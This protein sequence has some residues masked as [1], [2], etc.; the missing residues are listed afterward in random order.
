MMTSSS[1][2]DVNSRAIVLSDLN[3]S[4]RTTVEI[5]MTTVQTDESSSTDVL[6]TSSAEMLPSSSTESLSFNMEFSEETMTILVPSSSHQSLQP[7]G[8]NA[9]EPTSTLTIDETSSTEV[10]STS[11]VEMLPSASRESPSVSV[12]SSGETMTILVPSSSHQLLQSSVSSNAQEPTS[13]L[14]IDETS[15]TGVFSTPSVKMLPSSSRESPSF[16]VESSGDIPLEASS[17]FEIS[18]TEL[19]GSSTEYIN[20]TLFPVDTATSGHTES[21]SSTLV[22]TPEV[23]STTSRIETSKLTSSSSMTLSNNIPYSSQFTPSPTEPS[24]SSLQQIVTSTDQENIVTSPSHIVSSSTQELIS[25]S[26]PVDSMPEESRFGQIS[27]PL[28]GK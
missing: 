14:V 10:L 21:F 8:S 11:S 2:T 16:N 15:S 4:E 19:D 17:T 25:T 3:S 24:T 28:T 27:R 9:R 7:S 1:M 5:P 22:F 26:I 12:E 13:T 23:L 20:F 18:A 6:P